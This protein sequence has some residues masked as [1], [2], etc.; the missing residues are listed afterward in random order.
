MQK[1]K[2]L[3]LSFMFL[4]LQ[5]AS[6]QNADIDSSKIESTRQ[7]FFAAVDDARTEVIEEFD[8]KI[9]NARSA[10]DLETVE[11][12][13]TEKQEFTKRGTTPLSVNMLAFRRKL[14]SALRT[15]KHNF[16]EAI[17]KA[18]QQG[19]IDEATRL[20]DELQ[21]FEE[22]PLNS[23][24]WGSADYKIQS[25]AGDFQPF[26]NRARAYTNRIYVWNDISPTWPLKQFAPVTGGKRVPIQIAVTSPG[27]VFI[28]FSQGDPTQVETYLKHHSWQP[29]A[30]AFSYSAAGKTQM[31]IFRKHLPVGEHVIPWFNFSGP[32]LIKP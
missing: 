19:K 1:M 29:T 22:S 25:G 14:S 31:R 11:S 10:G 3:R 15:L 2:L 6:A 23:T 18:G 20:R 32:V 9:R 13:T 26:T 17:K 24:S 8:K 21:S 30:Y 4:L 5:S 27:W 12:L 28:A 7:A 16:E